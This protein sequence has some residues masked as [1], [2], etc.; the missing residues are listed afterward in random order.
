VTDDDFVPPESR[1]PPGPAWGLAALLIG[2]TL[3]LSACVLMVFNVLLFRGGLG[4]IPL[5]LA[6]PAAVVA[7]SGVALLGLCAVVFGFR[8]W[9]GAV[10]GGESPAFGVAG[11]AAAVVGL[12]AWLVA[13]A[14]L[15]AILGL[16]K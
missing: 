13:G 10:R 16:F 6:R 7:V 4:G 9:S 12:I 11:S 8:G 15:L 3:L 2:C 14:D 1:F 5:A